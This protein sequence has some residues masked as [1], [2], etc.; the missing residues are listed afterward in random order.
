[1]CTLTVPFLFIAF[2]QLIRFKIITPGMT[3]QSSRKEQVIAW[4]WSVMNELVTY[5]FGFLTTRLV[6]SMTKRA[7]GRLR[8]HFIE[9]CKPKDM[10]IICPAGLLTNRYIE[11]YECTQANHKMIRKSYLSF[12]SGHSSAI[13][14][15]MV[16]LVV[17]HYD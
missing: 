13:A 11:D 3:T 8:P 14:Y 4:I 1:M 7:T 5:L 9:I 2:V 16:F 10:D 15:A 12:F 6:T 17:R